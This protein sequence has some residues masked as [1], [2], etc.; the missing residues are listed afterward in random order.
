MTFFTN[1]VSMGVGIVKN[2]GGERLGDGDWGLGAEI[3]W[4]V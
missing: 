2:W 3:D 4:R 1:S